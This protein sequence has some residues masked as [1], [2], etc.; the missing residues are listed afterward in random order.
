MAIQL[1]KSSQF[2]FIRSK[3]EQHLYDTVLNFEKSDDLALRSVEN[4]VLSIE[5]FFD[6]LESLYQNPK[7][8][9]LIG[10]KSFP[11]HHG[12]YRIFYRISFVTSVDFE[13]TLLDID[14]NKQSN[15]D[16]FPIHLITFDD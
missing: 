3:I 5:N 6:T 12:R 13:I 8:Q 11:I 14:D 16:R 4:F 9:D 15:L 7:P 2:E 1:K 10:E